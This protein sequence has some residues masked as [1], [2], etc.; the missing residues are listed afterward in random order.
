MGTTLTACDYELNGLNILQSMDYYVEYNPYVYRIYS[1]N[2]VDKKADLYYAL[3]EDQENRVQRDLAVS[4]AY[5]T[6][7]E[8]KTLTV[9]IGDTTYTRY[10]DYNGAMQGGL[11]L[12]IPATGDTPEQYISFYATTGEIETLVQDA[13]DT[14]HTYLESM[15]PIE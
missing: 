4:W 7:N 2:A 1:I 11:N 8:I 12:V 5:T 10:V 15:Q 9:T 13:M 14:Y 3:K 6:E